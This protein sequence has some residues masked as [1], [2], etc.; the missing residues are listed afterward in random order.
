V[1]AVDG[2]ASALV[3]ALGD[4]SV[5]IAPAGSLARE[6]RSVGKLAAGQEVSV[7]LDLD[8]PTASVVGHVWAPGQPGVGAPGVSVAARELRPDGEPISLEA[9]AEATTDATGGFE[10]TGLKPGV[11][12]EL[13]AWV[14]QA[15]GEG[16]IAPVSRIVTAPVVGPDADLV[17]ARRGRIACRVVADPAAAPVSSRVHVE[18]VGPRARARLASADGN[19][20]LGD[21]FVAT[22][23]EPGTYRV[24][25][26]EDELAVTVTPPFEIT[27]AG[28]SIETTLVASKGRRVSVRIVKPDGSSP[29]VDDLHVAVRDGKKIAL[30]LVDGRFCLERVAPG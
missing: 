8:A 17:L 27:A 22:G 16:A 18:L 7:A 5:T 1:T 25:V 24:R 4:A 19:V 26:V 9:S 20:D 23:L 13:R 15:S 29:G 12:Y 2:R 21:S 3:P 14:F 30:C 28:E 6:V 11:R 10:L